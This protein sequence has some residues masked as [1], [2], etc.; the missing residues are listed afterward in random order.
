MESNT[1]QELNS[2]L[3][4]IVGFEPYFLDV[5]G[6]VIC[7]CCLV[8]RSGSPVEELK[9]TKTVKNKDGDPTSVH[10]CG[11]CKYVQG[12]NLPLKK[13][14][15]DLRKELGLMEFDIAKFKNSYLKPMD[16]YRFY[17]PETDSE[18]RLSESDLNEALEELRG[19][20]GMTPGTQISS[21][22]ELDSNDEVSTES[23]EED[24]PIDDLRETEEEEHDEHIE[25]ED[26]DM[27]SDT[28]SGDAINSFFDDE[29][30]LDDLFGTEEE[31]TKE[32]LG[33]NEDE[34]ID[35]DDELYESESEEDLGPDGFDNLD[36]DLGDDFW[37]E[38]K[39][40]DSSNNSSTSEKVEDFSSQRNT[41]G[42]VADVKVTRDAVIDD[43]IA[44]NKEASEDD[45]F[46][47]D[48]REEHIY[49]IVSR[50][51]FTDLIEDYDDSNAKK[52]VDR[53]LK[54]FKKRGSRDLKYKLYIDERTHECPVVDFEGSIRMIF[55]NTDIP[56][57]SYHA[58]NEINSRLRYTFDQS[59]CEYDVMTYIVYS[60]MIR[61]ERLNRVVKSISKQIAFNLKV[62]GIFKPISIIED[63]DQYFYTTSEKDKPTIDRFTFDN[64]SGNVDVAATKSIALISRWENPNLDNEW[65][66]RKE[67]SNRIALSKGANIGYEDL[68]MHMTAAIRFIMIPPKPDGTINV[69]IT[70]YIESLDIY[71]RDGLGS[72]IGVL[73]H[74][75][76]AEFPQSQ[77]HIYYEF[78]RTMIPSPT[79]SRYFK[80]ESI[81][82]VNVNRDMA[83]FNEIIKTVSE[84]NGVAPTAQFYVEG[85]PFEGSPE[86]NGDFWPTFV[87][88]PE[89]RKTN[90]DGDRIDWRR[91]VGKKSLP[92]FL[93]DK[94]KD[95]R[96][97]NLDDR[98]VRLSILD[99]EGYITVIQPQVFRTKVEVAFALKALQTVMGTCSGPCSI[100]Q[101]IEANQSKVVGN[102]YM[103]NGFNSPTFFNGQY[104]TP[105]QQ[106][107]L[108]QQMLQQ[109]QMMAQQQMYGG[110]NG[111][112]NP[113]MNQGFGF[114]PMM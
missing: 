91:A 3:S 17:V 53:I 82:P 5:E 64:C 88:S 35:E 103:E 31:E 44:Q 102:N 24:L 19:N 107:M 9:R 15:T 67:I 66:Y 106:L 93:G 32:Y 85:E 2:E 40:K 6:K 26:D 78:N 34:D 30:D 92:K 101:Y 25:P 110:F 52:V 109:Q 86:Y 57:G 37:E 56:G 111:G 70:D 22:E 104:I 81:R 11:G 39:P 79:V 54:L 73:V 74:N 76:K 60:D 46:K 113:Q 36:D 84:Q 47:I 77:L 95:Y 80:N 105:D 18:C 12:A 62:K 100:R 75:I 90:K 28:A 48:G 96:N 23:L 50:S 99:K 1:L 114:G 68:S 71:V 112:F 61:D 4:T 7:K 69:T 27:N 98:R 94:F 42:S 108:Q 20:L 72:L 89:Y 63:S 43:M 59:D 8:D 83:Q 49:N 87:L 51:R 55:I 21:E 33:E 29:D 45:V 10:V 41:F 38:S 13:R 65:K 97:M 58:E 14:I 16:K